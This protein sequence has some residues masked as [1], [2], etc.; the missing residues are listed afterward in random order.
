MSHISA[1]RSFALDSSC[2][3]ACSLV[4]R[5]MSLDMMQILRG[6]PTW[7]A[8]TRC[9]GI[10]CCGWRSDHRYFC[11]YFQFP[12]WLSF[13]VVDPLIPLENQAIVSLSLTLEFWRKWKLERFH[14]IWDN[15]GFSKTR[16]KDFFFNWVFLMIGIGDWI[17]A[18]RVIDL[19][20]DKAIKSIWFIFYFDFPRV[21]IYIFFF[22]RC[23]VWTQFRR[24]VGSETI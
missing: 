1:T 17:K 19:C 5:G 8:Y 3:P 18:I 2:W 12:L 24:N 11:D 6:P 23:I 7:S 15:Y 20:H 9:I 10:V 21:Y 16:D 13:V 14:G 22:L 4:I